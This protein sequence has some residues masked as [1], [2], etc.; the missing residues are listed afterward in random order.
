[1]EDVAEMWREKD[2]EK[3]QEKGSKADAK[4]L[5]VERK[6]AAVGMQAAALV[7]YKEKRSATTAAIGQPETLPGAGQPPANEPPRK[8]L[9]IHSLI[10]QRTKLRQQELH[11]RQ[12]ELQLAQEKMKNEAEERRLMLELLVKIG[13]NVH[14]FSVDLVQIL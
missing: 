9:D 11:L 4:A 7:Q 3:E 12:Q 2:V 13:K 1:M 8:R 10:Q 6:N 14:H 5:E